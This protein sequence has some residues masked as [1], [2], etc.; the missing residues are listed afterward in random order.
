MNIDINVGNHNCMKFQN[1]VEK[2]KT[3][4]CFPT[5]PTTPGCDCS[6]PEAVTARGSKK[7][8]TLSKDFPAMF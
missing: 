3:R 8:W 6:G 7:R 1:Y 2:G 5:T 4:C